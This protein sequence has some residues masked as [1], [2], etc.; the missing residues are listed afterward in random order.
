MT[1]ERVTDEDLQRYIDAALSPE[2]R[3]EV[4][5]YLAAHPED[6]ERVAA[7]RAQMEVLH[8]LYDGVLDQP[9]PARMMQPPHSRRRT[10]L[11]HAA[12]VL[13]GISLGAGASWWVVGGGDNGGRR[14]TGFAERAAVAHIVYAPEVR[15]PVEVDATQEGHLVKWLSKRLGAPIKAP[16][17]GAAGYQ[18]VGGR[19]L[20]G[21][22]SPVAQFMYENEKGERLTLYL[23]TFTEAGRQTAF[24]YLHE[25][26]IGV[27]YW[28]DDRL[29]YAVV[30]EAGRE[31]LL[32]LSN[33]VYRQFNP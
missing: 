27:F 18:L 3:A 9:V 4:E 22:N 29:G 33:L 10:W 28:I 5:A 12:N 21:L 2:R 6:E 24:Q 14:E 19:L 31:E 8:G 15:H 30:S 11:R 32:R 17:L 26:S 16:H 7:Y 1:P 25:G 20:P 23:Q 13:V